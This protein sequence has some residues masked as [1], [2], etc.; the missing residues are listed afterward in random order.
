M[1]KNDV[2]DLEPWESA[3]SSCPYVAVAAC[4]HW[5]GTYLRAYALI[6]S[7]TER[8]LSDPGKFLRTETCAF[9]DN[10]PVFLPNLVVCTRA[11]P[12]KKKS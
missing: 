6:D 3:D 5:Y 10:L 4:V 2:I 9:C 11:S 8:L 12:H 7:T 1:K